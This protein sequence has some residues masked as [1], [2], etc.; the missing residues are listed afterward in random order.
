VP[1]R[2]SCALCGS[3]AAIA[4]PRR[5]QL[6]NMRP[7]CAVCRCGQCGFGFLNPRPTVAE[8]AEMY[9][10]DP[11]YAAS[12]ATRGATRTRFYHARMRRL[13]RWRPQRGALLGVGCLEGG[14]ALEVARRRGWEVAAVEFSPILADHARQVLGIDVR[15]ARAWD[16]AEF[17]SH[18]FDAIVSQ[19]LEHVPDPGVTLRQ[20]RELLTPDGLLL[21]EVPN[22][23]HALVDVLKMAV[24]RV[25]GERAYRWFHRDLTFEFHTL[26]FS[27]ATIRRLLEREGFEVLALRTHLRA[28]PLYLGRGR[29]RWIQGPIHA[30]G[31]LVNRGPCIEVIARPLP[32]AG[33]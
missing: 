23:F 32:A 3:R 5:T 7:P 9:L 27:P 19:S 17:S 33:G 13:E 1:E 10:T 12:N 8:L 24:V 22:Q 20:C 14:Y 15:M 16:L 26:Y 11:Y 4:E 2:V 29:R 25:A 6:L 30:L 21:L 28:H 31:G 18:H